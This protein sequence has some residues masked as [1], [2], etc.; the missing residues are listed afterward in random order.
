V[1]SWAILH[2]QTWA[3]GAS[4]PLHQH[5]MSKLNERWQKEASFCDFL[6]YS[7]SCC[8][9][10]KALVFSSI[11]Y[12]ISLHV[13]GL[14]CSPPSSHYIVLLENE[15]LQWKYLGPIGTQ[16][17]AMKQILLLEKSKDNSLHLF[18][19]QFIWSLV[20]EDSEPVP[21]S[22]SFFS[23]DVISLPASFSI[24]F[25]PPLN[26]TSWPRY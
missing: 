13:K 24:Y 21:P 3:L 18:N 14:M 10:N 7:Y 2:L 19:Y 26:D 6:S 9:E 1:Q 16:G 22:T 17:I 8:I 20:R 25:I 11:S 15:K 4:T 23:V 5:S 12:S